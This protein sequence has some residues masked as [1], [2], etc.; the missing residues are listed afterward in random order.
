MF[1]NSAQDSTKEQQELVK[2]EKL[3]PSEK[4]KERLLK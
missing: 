3:Q 4:L 1:E 2:V